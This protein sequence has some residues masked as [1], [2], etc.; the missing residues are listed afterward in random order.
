[1]E[2]DKKSVDDDFDTTPGNRVYPRYDLKHLIENQ[3]HTKYNTKG[4][5]HPQQE[6]G[7]PFQER[8][9]LLVRE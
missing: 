8:D 3:Q 6:R 2:S 5:A 1:L 9:Q 4:N 7:V